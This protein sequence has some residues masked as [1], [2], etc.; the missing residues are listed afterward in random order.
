VEYVVCTKCG[1]RIRA[2][3]EWCLRCG[4]EMP[5][6]DAPV[7]VPLWQSLGLSR[8]KKLMLAGGTA[9]AVMTLVAIM[10]S[11]ATPTMDE[12]ARPAG[13]AATRPAAPAVA[14]RPEPDPPAAVAASP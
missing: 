10:W 3:R 12:I 14:E 4:G 11:T 1:T 2:G 9:V 6:A 5:A 8:E 13:V 7:A